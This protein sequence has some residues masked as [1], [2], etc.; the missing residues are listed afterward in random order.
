LLKKYRPLLSL[1]F[2]LFG[3]AVFIN[4]SLP[5][6]TTFLT[7]VVIEAIIEK[8]DLKYLMVVT[9]VFTLSIAILSGFKRFAEQ[10]VYQHR[11]KMNSFYL[12]KVANKGLTTDYLNQENE[13]FRKLQAESFNCCKG[14]C[15]PCYLSYLFIQ[16]LK[17]GH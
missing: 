13:R 16:V 17:H 10:Y 7:K 9:L 8:S 12:R 2:R 15:S 4:I 3:L 5:L 6:L 14:R 11:F 1:A